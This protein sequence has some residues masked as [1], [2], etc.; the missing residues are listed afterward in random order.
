ME[1]QMTPQ[2]NTLQPPP[3]KE[4]SWTWVWLMIIATVFTANFA[5]TLLGGVPV[6]TQSQ[7]WEYSGE[8]ATDSQLVTKFT[9]A[10]EKHWEIVHCRR[11]KSSTDWGYECI[12]KRPKQ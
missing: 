1:N 3:K 12:F 6:K 5:V 9:E 2:N 4:K 7:K 8:F 10:G 11:A